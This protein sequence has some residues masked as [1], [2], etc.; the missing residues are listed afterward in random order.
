MT[1]R[2]HMKLPTPAASIRCAIYT[3][4]SSEEGLA[5]EFNSLDLMQTPS[6]LIMRGE[7]SSALR[8]CGVLRL[9][10]VGAD[11]YLR[12][13]IAIPVGDTSVTVQVGRRQD[14]ETARNQI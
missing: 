4:K 12:V 5:Q 8:R 9:K 7:G 13:S 14:L 11:I 2:A 10:L 1:R 6:P 3:R